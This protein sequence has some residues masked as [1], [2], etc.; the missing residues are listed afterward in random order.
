[1]RQLTGI[2]HRVPAVLLCE[3]KLHRIVL[4]IRVT[5]P[6]TGRVFKVRV[7]YASGRKLDL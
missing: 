7:M 1:M 2:T 4:S 5:S 3:R 6:W